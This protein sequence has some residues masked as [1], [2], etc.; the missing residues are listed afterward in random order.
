MIPKL[1]SQ[2]I[3]SYGK[4]ISTI[5]NLSLIENFRLISDTRSI[6][7]L[8]PLT[9]KTC[10]ANE[11]KLH[12]GAQ[13]SPDLND[14]FGKLNSLKSLEIVLCDGVPQ[15]LAAAISKLENLNVLKWKIE[16]GKCF[17]N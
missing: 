13:S 14:W 5:P 12:L 1:H 10:K 9:E 8:I 16:L 3:Q 2:Y 4:A 15:G 11:L 6:E 17:F 7:F